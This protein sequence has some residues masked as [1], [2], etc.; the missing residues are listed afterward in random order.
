MCLLL[1]RCQKN[2]VGVFSNIISVLDLTHL[3]SSNS[4]Y[5]CVFLSLSDEQSFLYLY[6]RLAKFMFDLPKYSHCFVENCM[7]VGG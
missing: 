6:V 3:V 4:I 7:L 2:L 1:F 5:F